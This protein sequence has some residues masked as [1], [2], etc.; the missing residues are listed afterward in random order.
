MN[1]NWLTI[2]TVLLDM[3]GTLLDLHFDNLFWLNHLPRRYAELHGIC[4]DL[5][6]QQLYAQFREKQGT[7]DWY[8]IEYWSNTL[9]IDIRQLKEELRHLI[10][11][12]PFVQEFLH[13][14]KLCNKQRVL[15]TNAHPQSLEMKLNVTG[16]GPQLDR[17]VSSHHYGAPKE[18][19]HFWAKLQE[20]LDFTPGRTLFIDD[21]EPVLQAACAFGIGHL[22]TIS[23]PDSQQAPRTPGAFPAIAHFD[24]IFPAE[25]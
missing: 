12:R 3:D 6:T 24:E 5:A 23:Q 1:L 7:L 16:I 9:Q 18:S 21:S 8:C 2:D 25:Q 20:Q 17:I 14:L 13:C 22:L 15:I 4:L 11:E 19:Q 10:R